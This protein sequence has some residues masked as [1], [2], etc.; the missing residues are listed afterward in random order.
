MKKES[1]KKITIDQLAQTIDTLAIAVGNGFR[2]IDERFDKVDDKFN[3]IDGKFN[4]IDDR[5]SKLESSI[6]MRFF[7]VHDQLGG[8]QN[9]MA[10]L[11]KIYE[12][13]DSE[14]KVFRAKIERLE[15]AK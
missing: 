2:N 14:H 10:N 7:E 3:K 8:L 9:Q 4:K 12:R 1:A 13:D 6:N 5:F 15:K 11:E